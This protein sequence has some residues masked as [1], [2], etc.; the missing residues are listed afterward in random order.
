MGGLGPGAGDAL[1]AALAALAQKE[2]TISEVAE[3]LERRGFDRADA[4][5][6]LDVLVGEGTLDDERFARRY[7][8]DKRDLAGWGNDRIRETLVRRGIGGD[9]V[10]EALREPDGE[11]ELARATALVEGRGYDLAE[12]RDRGRAIGL[13]A[14]RGFDSDVAYEAVRA[15]ERGAAG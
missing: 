1:G 3:L 12:E 7:A 14:R 5:A 9:V 15:A 11:G 4:E 13:L 10:D 6:A 2:R 8:E